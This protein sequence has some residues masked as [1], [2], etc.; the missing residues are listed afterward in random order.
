[1][2]RTEDYILRI[3]NASPAELVVITYDILVDRINRALASAEADVYIEN[4]NGARDAVAELVGAL[5][6]DN[7]VALEL[8]P[9]YMYINTLLMGALVYEKRANLEEALTIIAPLREG[10]VEVSQ[11]QPNEEAVYK[12][13]PKVYSGLTYGPKGPNDFIDDNPTRGFKA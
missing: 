10:F 6:A 12:N 1:M 11:S 4:V 2:A 7:P 8:H 3:T 5:E 9:I 13:A